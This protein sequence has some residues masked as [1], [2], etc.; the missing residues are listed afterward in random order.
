[1]GVKFPDD[2][3]GYILLTNDGGHPGRDATH[4]T[5]R[6]WIAPADGTVRIEGTLKH[7]QKPG[8]G[9][10]ARVVSSRLGMLG[11]WQAQ[12]SE[13]KTE[14]TG[15]VVKKGDTLDFVTDA[16]EDDNSD[17]FQWSPVVKSESGKQMWNA[18]K[19]F[20]PPP[21][22]PLSRLA[23][24]AQALLATNEFLFRGLTI[25]SNDFTG[26]EWHLVWSDEFAKNGL[27]D[28]HK[29]TYETGRVRNNEAQTYT[30][31]P[32]NARVEQSK[33]IIEG[34]RESFDGAEYTAASLT[35]QGLAAW[36][37]G[38]V[39]VRAKL[40]KAVGTWPAIWMLGTDISTVSWPRCGEI[41]IMEHVAF[42]P[43]VIHATLHQADAGGEHI[44]KGEQVR[45]PDFGDVFHVYAVDWLPDRLDFF[46]DNKKYFTY[47]N[48]GKNAWTFN[49][50]YYLLINLAIGGDWG[51]QKGI[52]A[53]AFPQ[54]YEI[55]FV[56]VYQKRK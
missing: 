51:G 4:A 32:A 41:D 23:L 27:P 11:V 20:G 8:N 37:Y 56:R 49:K 39:V 1:M 40:P 38:R 44:S 34:Q 30:K 15:I 42:D 14:V 10:R 43:G 16:M 31:R 12:N 18:H 53:A 33:L 5:I 25:M 47:A 21:P 52:D 45:V 22:A 54:K 2:A 24:Y 29:W 46:V 9:V 50:P 26:P 3:L 17:A 6:R 7:G 19:D 13:A 36:Q 48:D 28:P 55:D 35:T